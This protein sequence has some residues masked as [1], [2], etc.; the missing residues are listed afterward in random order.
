[1]SAVALSVLSSSANAVSE[2]IVREY[3]TQNCGSSYHFD[4]EIQIRL[5]A[6]H[7][8][9]WEQFKT[10]AQSLITKN[11]VG[12]DSSWV[13]VTLGEVSPEKWEKFKT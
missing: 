7:D 8:A 5:M 11:M 13:I 3:W 2:E 4:P 1:M 10:I 6:L 12:R 9:Q